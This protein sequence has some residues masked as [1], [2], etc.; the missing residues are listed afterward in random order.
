VDTATFEDLLGSV[1]NWGRW[2]KDD[3]RGTLNHVT[4][5]AVTAAAA[6]VTVGRSISLAHD[7]DTV[8]GPDNGRPA[9]H[10]MTRLGD[11]GGQEPQVNTDFVGMDFHGK[12]VTHVDALC[13]CVFRGRMYNDADPA[14]AVGSDGGH[15]MT[16]DQMAGGIVARGVLV[17]VPR[18]RG[19]SWLEPGEAI[20][21]DELESA[22]SAQGVVPA[23]GDVVLIR[24]GHRRRRRE[25]GAWD[26]SDS[27]AGLAP[28]A[29]TW[30]HRNRTAMLGSDGDSDARPS[31][32]EGVASPIHALALAAMGLPL[33]DNANLEEL[34][35][36]CAELRRWE[37][38][39]CLAPLRIPGGT[40]SPV[41]PLAVL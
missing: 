31:P 13:H 10:Y 9:L 20:S 21:L 26:P 1:R 29:M 11:V 23:A 22:L 4:P 8:A 38:L 25:L 36:A 33:I 39:F 3:Q 32:V 15:L 27:S 14:A 18:F 6:L 7:L 5:Q 19:T 35:E 17:D 37:F 16:V 28:D 40:G 30:F 34:A 2:G 41:N 12:S 24:T